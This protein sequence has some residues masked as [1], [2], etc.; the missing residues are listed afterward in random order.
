MRMPQ[1]RPCF[2]AMILEDEDIFD[3]LKRRK[4][5]YP[6]LIHSKKLPEVFPAHIPELLP[7]RRL[8]DDIMMAKSRGKGIEFIMGLDLCSPFC[9][10]KREFIRE[11]SYLP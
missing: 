4:G 2:P 8:H 10:Q 5:M 6:F 1:R 9:A 7:A 11:P 3:M